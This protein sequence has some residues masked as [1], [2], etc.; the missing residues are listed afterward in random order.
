MAQL[1]LREIE[2]EVKDYWTGKDIYNAVIESRIGG[3]KFYFCQ[4]PPFTSGHAHVGHAWNTTIKDWV[5]RYQTMQ[6]CDVFRRAGWDMHGLPIE[7]KVEETVLKSRSKKEI[8]QFGIENFISECK[9][10][11]I[12][13]MNSMTVQLSR[14]G[15]WLDWEDPYMTLDR[16]YMESVW[17]GIKKAHDKDLLYEDK[18][19]IHWCPRCETAVAGYEVKDEYREV[20]DHS[21]YVKAKVKGKDNEYVLVWTTTPWTLPAN[22]AIAVNPGYQYVKASYK[23]ET[24][25]LVK[26]RLPAVLKKDYRIIEE[27]PGSKL[28]GLEYIS[29]LD[30]PL[31][32]D[33][34][35][36][37][38]LA[39]E[40]VTLEDGTGCVHIAPGHGEEDSKI[41]KRY[42][43]VAPSPVDE[44]GKLTAE[45]YKGI[46]IRDANGI[47]IKDLEKIGKLLR[48]ETISH[49]YP[50]CW[51]CKT[52][53]IMRATKQW[54]LAVSK[55][56]EQLLANNKGVDWV[57]D[58]IGSGRF[59][60]WLMNARDWCISRQRY[61]NTPLPVW[62]CECGHMEV[63]GSIKEL[64]E[65]SAHELD[66]DSLDLHRPY[67]D[68]VHL[69]CKCGKE[70]H[71][72]K[73]VLD[74]WI[75][76]G[77][78]SWANLLYP[79]ETD[80]FDR[81]FPADFITEGSDQTRGW[82]YSLLVMGTIAFD[83]AP[84][85]QVLYHGFSL[86]SEGRKMSKSLG[87]VVDPMD[88]MDKHGADVFRFYVLSATVPWDDLCFSWEGL[89]SVERN[90][91]ILW[92]VY[93]F[94]DTYM[95]LD[96]YD[97]KREYMMELATE[98]KWI[99]SRYN[100]LVKEV[101]SA[102]E[103]RYP[104]EY[105]RPINDFVLE[106][107][108]WYVKLIR[109]RVWMEGEDPRKM[110]VHYT[111][112]TVLTGLSLLLAPVTPHY[113]EYLYRRLTGEKSVH[114][115]NW[116]TADES[117][118]DPILEK[119]MIVAQQIV[120]CANAARQ[121]AGIKLRWPITRIMIALKEDFD[122]K[123]YEALILKS[124]NAKSLELK[125]IKAG[126]AVKPNLATVGPKYKK[127]AGRIMQHLKT[128][129]A[130][131]VKEEVDKTG[132]YKIDTIVLEATDLLFESKLPEDLVAQEFTGGMVYID[133]KMD[134]RLVSESM[135]REVIRRIQAMRKEMNLQEMEAVSSHL[136]C[137]QEFAKYVQEN[138][139]AIEKETRSRISLEKPAG[140]SYEKA[141]DIE[142][143]E[144][145]I[146][147]VK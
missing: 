147:I 6:G 52:P 75:D 99:L 120:E 143:S 43:L 24:L 65:K 12:R 77:S 55:I 100:S 41:G 105:C 30:I 135:A 140:A 13:N 111:M 59:E 33:I 66:T 72:V 119:D 89:V 32:K 116:P 63:I 34:V 128:A 133:S 15:A 10:F 132:K 102:A 103:R 26:D 74:V 117:M 3:K 51:R 54:F 60:N 28:E 57:P 76:S 88:V 18:Q 71:R 90:L 39:P 19:V 68:K 9:K 144:I 73:D 98:D 85:K 130:A 61:W 112:H 142:G 79:H 134:P 81:L 126:V 95:K 118:I 107:S 27:F 37:V 125:E 121:T 20:T 70:M 22:V 123:P 91:N 115:Q 137:D 104:H 48:E 84:Y 31:Q 87:N 7:V 14:L 96:N 29:I 11:A 110:S 92:N 64:A 122:I 25:I 45:P 97:P 67:I 40:A 109:D 139:A 21:I 101:S 47:I 50:H 8:E 131:K 108:R 5:L 93:S 4:G 46:Y 53:L 1:N 44:T 58:W 69:K 38:A 138:Q 145:M 82:F 146:R 23:G 106:L 113:S 36:K 136:E 80:K 127:D 83:K 62:T 56:R 78:A 129:D 124:C 49:R 35:H 2:K 141:W 17:Y 16:K 86:D 114:L 42:G 94:A